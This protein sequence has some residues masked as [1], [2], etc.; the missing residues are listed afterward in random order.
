M[1]TSRVHSSDDARLIA[2]RSWL[3]HSQRDS[4]HA[5]RVM[6]SFAKCI[7]HSFVRR[8]PRLLSKFPRISTRFLEEHQPI[9]RPPLSPQ[10][11]RKKRKK[12]GKIPTSFQAKP[13][14]HVPKIRIQIPERRLVVIRQRRPRRPR[15]PAVLP[16]DERGVD[17]GAHGAQ[18]DEADADAVA[19]PVARGVA[20]D[21]AVGGDDA[22]D[23]AEADLPGG[24][25]GAAVVAAEVHVVPAHDDGQ[26]AVG[27]HAHEEQRAVLQRQAVVHGEEDAEAGE[28]EADG[29]EDEEEP[30]LRPVRARGHEHGED[31]GRGPGRHRVQLGLD[32]AVVVRL[33]DGGGEEG[34]AVRGPVGSSVKIMCCQERVYW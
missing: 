2:Q 34:V 33:E 27:A 7:W 11:E 24:A 20:R 29:R 3:S 15:P 10:K 28:R 32:R 31:E 30:V 19:G 22:A 17:A 13:S 25:D 1:L 26:R 8:A 23:V 14:E 6:E 21:E 9:D 12:K 16:R 18:A 5:M 4:T